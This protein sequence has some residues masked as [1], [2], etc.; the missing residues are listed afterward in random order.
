MAEAKNAED[1][2]SRKDLDALTNGN[3]ITRVKT[4]VE[5]AIDAEA[6]PG[7]SLGSEEKAVDVPE[8]PPNGG[9]QAWL[10]VVG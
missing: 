3:Q 10:Q 1:L 2:R 5:T 6:T 8:P 4:P 9:L 7:P